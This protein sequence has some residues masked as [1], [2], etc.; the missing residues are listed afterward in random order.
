MKMMLAEMIYTGTLKL[1]VGISKKVKS[2]IKMCVK[3][4]TAQ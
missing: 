2:T 3:Y 1:V 4:N